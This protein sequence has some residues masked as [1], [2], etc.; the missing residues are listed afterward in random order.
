MVDNNVLN[1]W[2]LATLLKNSLQRTQSH[3]RGTRIGRHRHRRRKPRQRRGPT[4]LLP[5]TPRANS[6]AS[7][8]HS[9]TSQAGPKTHAPTTRSSPVGPPSKPPRLERRNR[10]K[11]HFSFVVDE[12]APPSRAARQR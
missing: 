1:A 11:L 10:N 12:P 4:R 5:S 6:A 2:I 3:R 9:A 8:T 7:S